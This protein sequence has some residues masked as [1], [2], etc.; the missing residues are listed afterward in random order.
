MAIGTFSIRRATPEDCEAIWRVHTRA[1]REIAGSHYTAE[2]IEAWAGP[3]EPDHYA[4]PIRDKEFFVAEEGGA[5][6]GFGTLARE[7]EVEAVY[8]SPDTVRRGVGSALLQKLEARARD[9]GLTLL[10]LDASLNAAPF[11]EGAGFEPRQHTKHRLRSGVEIACVRMT[12]S[13]T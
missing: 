3:R 8:V 9:L 7:G 6:I 5:V 11:Y 12:K 1:I 13:L 10:R 2:E 4:G